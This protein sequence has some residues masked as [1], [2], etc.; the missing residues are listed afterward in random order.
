LDQ[1]A[2]L[3]L[4]QVE[5]AEHLRRL[6]KLL[7]ELERDSS[8][9]GVV[10]E[11]FLVAHTL[12]GSAAMLGL[13]A[14]ATLAHSLEDVLQTIREKPELVIPDLVDLLFR[15]LDTASLLAEN[16]LSTPAGDCDALLRALQQA[17]IADAAQLGIDILLVE[18]SPT[19]RAFE[20]A[21]FEEAG[22]IGAT[23]GSLKEAGEL[24]LVRPPRIVIVGHRLR[25]GDG[26]GFAEMLRNP[27]Q[28]RETPVV[29]TCE[30]PYP[31]QAAALER[32]G[33]RVAVRGGP[34]GRDALIRLVHEMVESHGA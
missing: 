16:G 12:K 15:A 24:L 19:L 17:A 3:Q 20:C 10:R 14:L 33:A 29:V 23:A 32:L 8:D 13:D 9:R 1:E 27:G 26:L 2:L 22:F 11:M 30:Q 21:G 6:S 31:E 5:A 18:D 7:L 28:F 25:D 34:A 4:F